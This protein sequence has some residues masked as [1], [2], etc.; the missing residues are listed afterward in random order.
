MY[1]EADA[2]EGNLRTILSTLDACGTTFEVICVSDGSTDATATNARRVGDDRVTVL[3][4]PANAGKGHA[5]RHG[6]MRASGEFIGWLDADLDLHPDSLLLF[7]A[8]ARSRQLDIIVGSKRHPDSHVDYP[9]RRRA[10]SWLYQQLVRL[11]FGLR[12]RDTQ[13]GIKLFRRETLNA[14][15][16]ITMVKR[17]AFDLEVLALAHAC[18]FRRIEEAPVD[19]QYRFSGTSVNWR[20]IYRAL[21]DTAAIFYRL[22]L[23]R[24]YRLPDGP[25]QAV[26]AVT[27]HAAENDARG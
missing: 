16:P 2:I 11:L 22:R 15:L 19:L 18:G 17:Y 9:R 8:L 24:S 20:A 4:Y 6:S 12:V 27:L 25:L 23:R 14:V 1:N 3:E 5:L 10:Y 26:D 21:L 13:V 7:L